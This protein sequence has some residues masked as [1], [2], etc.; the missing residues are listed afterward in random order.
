MELFAKKKMM[1]KVS[2]TVAFEEAAHDEIEYLA[3]L[4]RRSF[5]A[6]VTF[7]IEDYL[8]KKFGPVKKN[9]KK[10]IDKGPG[11]EVHGPGEGK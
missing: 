3:I 9:A 11:S 7:M 8:E 6:Q 2:K 10:V 4:N 5:T 1:K